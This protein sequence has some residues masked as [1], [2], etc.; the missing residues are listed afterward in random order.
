METKIKKWGNSLGI[1][2]P[3]SVINDLS[4]ENGSTVEIIKEKDSIIIKAKKEFNLEELIE[5]ISDEN[6]HSETD[7]GKIEGNEVW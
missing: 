7:F 6:T 1:R 4:L 3:I 2:I 5:N